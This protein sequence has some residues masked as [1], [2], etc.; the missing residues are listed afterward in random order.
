MLHIVDH[1]NE[2]VPL[3]RLKTLHRLI[4][5]FDGPQNKSVTDVFFDHAW[6]DPQLCRLALSQLFPADAHKR[7]DRLGT[8]YGAGV[9]K[10]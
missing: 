3:K 10:P 9:P 5:M 6:L 7:G 8:G 2:P 4:G 1:A